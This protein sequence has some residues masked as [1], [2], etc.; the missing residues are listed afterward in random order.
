MTD[1]ISLITDACE[2]ELEEALVQ[3]VSP[4]RIDGTDLYLIS[5]G[6]GCAILGALEDREE[7]ILDK[8]SLREFCQMLTRIRERCDRELSRMEGDIRG[9]LS[10]RDY[11]Y[12]H[13]DHPSDTP[14]LEVYHVITR[15][16]S[17]EV[18]ASLEAVV[19]LTEPTGGQQ[20]IKD[21]TLGGWTTEDSLAMAR[22]LRS[23]SFDE[24]ATVVWWYAR[25]SVP[26]E[27]KGAMAMADAFAEAFKHRFKG[28]RLDDDDRLTS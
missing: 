12:A 1:C 6:L 9:I 17:A 7:D 22:F 15:A 5:T 16:V 8:L 19:P 18:A 2:A 28:G 3:A 23:Y 24:F 26:E 27:R 11:S 4:A 25:N 20:M 13:L 21:D 14:F 10:G